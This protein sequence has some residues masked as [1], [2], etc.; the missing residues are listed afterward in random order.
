MPTFR[1]S[2]NDKALP[3]F[4]LVDETNRRYH[5]KI[6]GCGKSIS[7]KNTSNLVS[8]IKHSHSQL[9][10]EQVNP[11]AV[12]IKSIERKRLELV[13]ACTEMVTVNGRPFS[14]LVDSGF[15]LAIDTQ[16]CELENSGRP[17]ALHLNKFAELK[18]YIVESGK[19]IFD[20]IRIEAAKKVVSVM[21]DSGS[22]NGHSI[23]STFIR[24]VTNDTVVTRNIGMTK[25]K[26]R[27]R[28]PVLKQMILDQLTNV[29]VTSEQILSFTSDNARNMT[30]TARLIDGEINQLQIDDDDEESDVASDDGE[31]SGTVYESARSE[32][33]ND[34]QM[35]IDDIRAMLAGTEVE[36]GDEIDENLEAILNDNDID[37]EYE[38]NLKAQFAGQ[39][40]NI[41]RIPCAAHTLQ[42]AV[43]DFLDSP[44]V[45][46]LVSLSRV[47]AKELHRPVSV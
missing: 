11:I 7:G 39:T 9:Y 40:L 17:L 13:Q 45:K 4:G 22:K 14:C 31:E 8:H 26:E 43:K 16:L 37:E 46:T 10:L 20:K 1:N 23:L 6:D 12:D 33:A 3:Y 41:H 36:Q 30:D 35:S 5:C 21:V 34:G 18:E 32:F 25:I 38:R 19:T 29:G 47:V 27:H 42:L 24:Y 44:V 2:Q 28:S 15:Q